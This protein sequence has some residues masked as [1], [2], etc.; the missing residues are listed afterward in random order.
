MSSIRV[1]QGSLLKFVFFSQSRTWFI[2]FYI[3]WINLITWAPL[4]WAKRSLM[5]AAAESSGQGPQSAGSARGKGLCEW[6]P[7]RTSFDFAMAGKTECVTLSFPQCSIDFHLK[8]FHFWT[9]F[10]FKNV[11]ILLLNRLQHCNTL[12]TPRNSL[13]IQKISLFLLNFLSIVCNQHRLSLD[14][15]YCGNSKIRILNTV[16]SDFCFSKFVFVFKFCFFVT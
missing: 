15:V 13:V 3:K 9:L 11:K 12:K 16:L 14:D 2:F 6:V 10:L 7:P 5:M 4:I 8:F 1:V